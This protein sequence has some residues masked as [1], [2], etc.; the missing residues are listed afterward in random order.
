VHS[1]SL[2]QKQKNTIL[3]VLCGSN[4]LFVGANLFLPFS[5]I[6]ISINFLDGRSLAGRLGLGNQR[7]S[8]QN[9]TPIDHGPPK[10]PN[11][12]VPESQ[13][14]GETKAAAQETVYI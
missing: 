2:V 9:S 8:R 13:T 11:D 6:K 1:L 5:A 7:R 4:L 14:A 10:P 3:N 12:S